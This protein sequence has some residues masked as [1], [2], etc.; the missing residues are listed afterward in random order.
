MGY[1]GFYSARDFIFK[2]LCDDQIELN[3]IEGDQTRRAEVDEAMMM[4]MMRR[5]RGRYRRSL[6]YV[7]NNSNYIIT[8]IECFAT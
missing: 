6:T 8:N 7:H 5:R 1:W 2:F 4:M 3:S